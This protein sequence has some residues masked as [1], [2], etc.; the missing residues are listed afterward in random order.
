MGSW[1]DTFKL[2]GCVLDIYYQ[3][4]VILGE[5]SDPFGPPVH[6]LLRHMSP[7]SQL[8]FEK[9]YPSCCSIRPDSFGGRLLMG[10]KIN[11]HDN[12]GNDQYQNGERLI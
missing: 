6:L 2:L 9:Y 8:Y 3:L 12:N 10:E 4:L 5:M 1:K 11:K 7:L